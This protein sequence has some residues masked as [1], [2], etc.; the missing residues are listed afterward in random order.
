[1]EAAR[2]SRCESTRCSMMPPDHQDRPA[3]A[4]TEQPQCEVL[5]VHKRRRVRREGTLLVDGHDYELDD[6]FL[7]CKVVTIERRLVDRN[8]DKAPHPSVEHEGQ[9]LELPPWTQCSTPSASTSRWFSYPRRA[10]LGIFPLTLL[11]RCNP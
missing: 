6:F 7:T 8:T 3:D 9:R 10:R 4:L 11:E 2:P 5:T 1:M